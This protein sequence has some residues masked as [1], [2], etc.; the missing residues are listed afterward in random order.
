MG[1]RD[2]RIGEAGDEFWERK[3]DGIETKVVGASPHPSPPRIDEIVGD[4]AVV[5]IVAAEIG[6]QTM[7]QL[8][9]API[10]VGFHLRLLAAGITLEMFV[11]PDRAETEIVL[12]A[13]DQHLVG[14]D[15]S[16]EAPEHVIVER[17]RMI[18]REIL[19]VAHVPGVKF[20]A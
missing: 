2:D 20:S 6:Q 5:L 16:V 13:V 18:E 3:L 8:P 9:I 17:V 1:I 19:D 15:R 10:C 12:V 14:I 7:M 11:G 4:D